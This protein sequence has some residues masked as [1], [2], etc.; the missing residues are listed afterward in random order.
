M[1]FEMYI[2]SLCLLLVCSEKKLFCN[3]LKTLFFE[4]RY[5][6]VNFFKRPYLKKNVYTYEGF[7]TYSFPNLKVAWRSFLR[8]PVQNGSS[9]SK[10]KK[11]SKRRAPKHDKN[12]DF[13][14]FYFNFEFCCLILEA[15]KF[16]NSFSQ[17]AMFRMGKALICL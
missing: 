2:V 7:Y 17:S 14:F 3:L 11:N 4:R 12:T 10:F 13:Y 6:R 15:A 9:Q 16:K 1:R 8:S 5:F